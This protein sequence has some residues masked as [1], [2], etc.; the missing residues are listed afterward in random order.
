[1]LSCSNYTHFLLSP[2]NPSLPSFTPGTTNLVFIAIM[3]FQECSINWTIQYVISLDWLF[4]HSEWFSG[5]SFKLPH[6]SMDCSFL[7][8]SD[9]SRYGCTQFI[10]STIYWR[11]GRLSPSVALV[12]QAT[13]NMPWTKSYSRQGHAL[14][15]SSHLPRKTTLEVN[16]DLI[17]IVRYQEASLLAPS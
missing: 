3:S 9:I 14:V 10:W 8:L 15:H 2:H 13:T 4:F 6:A 12:D 11:T 17:L 5:D 1:M 7:L 16:S